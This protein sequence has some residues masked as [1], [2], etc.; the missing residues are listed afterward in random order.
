MAPRRAQIRS[1]ET[2]LEVL[3]GSEFLGGRCLEDVVYP[4]RVDHVREHSGCRIRP[5]APALWPRENGSSDA[6]G[7]SRT[8]PSFA[9][10]SSW[11]LPQAA[12]R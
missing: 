10:E 1:W 12:H 8:A 5:N 11:E 4:I 3:R 2:R 7:S 6:A 9:D